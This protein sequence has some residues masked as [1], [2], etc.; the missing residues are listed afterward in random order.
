[1]SVFD[2]GVA[3]DMV[4]LSSY[5]KTSIRKAKRSCIDK[6]VRF[7]F[8]LQTYA[9]KIRRKKENVQLPKPDTLMIAIKVFI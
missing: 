7:Y 5:R 9:S 8:L 6:L 1:M 2:E 3:Y 4:S